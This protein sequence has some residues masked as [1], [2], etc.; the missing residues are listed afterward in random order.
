TVEAEPLGAE[1]GVAREEAVLIHDEARIVESQRERDEEPAADPQLRELARGRAQR[2][3]DAAPRRATEPI[4]PRP[5]D[6]QWDED[7]SE[8]GDERPGRDDHDRRSPEQL[9]QHVQERRG[10]EEE[11]RGLREADDQLA[12]RAMVREPITLELAL[13]P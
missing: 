9:G 2:E 10:Q 12:A 3:A 6:G 5:D 1:P 4:A 8:D 13:A 11:E 7:R